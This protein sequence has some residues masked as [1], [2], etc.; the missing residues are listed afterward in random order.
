M[1]ICK[2]D[3]CFACW[4]K[5]NQDASL[6]FLIDG[7]AEASHTRLAFVKGVACALA[8]GLRLLG[9]EPIEEMKSENTEQ[10]AE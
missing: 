8:S 7:D 1:K 6:R 9:V 5:G 10:A 4:N 3:S 2:G